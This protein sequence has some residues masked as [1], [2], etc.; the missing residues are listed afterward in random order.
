MSFYNNAAQD[1]A[2]S[3]LGVETAPTG[4]LKVALMTTSY[5]FDETDVFFSDLTG[6]ASGTGYTSGGQAVDNVTVTQSDAND[7]AIIDYDAETFST[8]TVSNVN[9]TV[10]YF[11]T[12]TPATSKLVEY[13]QFVEG[14][15]TLVS[16]NL[17]VTPNATGVTLIARA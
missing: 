16:G 1:M 12:G 4:T 7:G 2:A 6:E 5:T 9:A 8:I 3:Y 13:K 14:A 11:D 15:V 10:L 17:I